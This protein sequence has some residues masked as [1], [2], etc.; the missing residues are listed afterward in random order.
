MFTI[1]GDL[2]MCCFAFIKI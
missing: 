1:T 2:I